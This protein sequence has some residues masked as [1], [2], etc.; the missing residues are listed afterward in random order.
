MPKKS[1]VTAV[2][3][4]ELS[5]LNPNE[6]QRELMGKDLDLHKLVVYLKSQMLFDTTDRVIDVMVNRTIDG[7]STIDLSLNDYDRAIIRSWAINAKLDVQIDG[8][9]FRLVSCSKNPNDDLL[10]LTFEQREIAL[11]RSYPRPDTTAYSVENAKKWV[12]WASRDKTTR[13]EFVLNLIREVKEV[14]IPVVIPHLHQVQNIA[15]T[16]D[17]SNKWS[18][19]TVASTGGIPSDFNTK[20]KAKKLTPTKGKGG[21]AAVIADVKNAATQI[22]NAIS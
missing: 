11:L 13:A 14:N 22:E 12:K 18:N 2:Q 7:A 21:Y 3:K 15:K 4:L 20:H 17:V 10:Q 16:T 8:L 1:A 9:W 19:P 6:I 5:K